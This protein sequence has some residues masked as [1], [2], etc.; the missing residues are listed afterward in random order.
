MYFRV[1]LGLHFV[2]VVVVAM[3]IIS[4]SQASHPLV[5]AAIPLSLEWDLEYWMT[6]LSVPVLPCLPETQR[7]LSSCFCPSQ[8]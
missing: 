6:F 7:G 2:V 5:M 8:C 4:S 3:V 1:E